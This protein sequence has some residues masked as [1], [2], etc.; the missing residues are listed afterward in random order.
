[1]KSLHLCFFVALAPLAA[2]QTEMLYTIDRP[3]GFGPSWGA[4]LAPLAD[5]DGDGIPDLAVGVDAHGGG[6]AAS[7]HS[8]ADGAHLFDLQ[9]PPQPMFVGRSVASVSR[10]GSKAAP[11]LV[12]IGSRSGAWNSPNGWIGVFSGVD[13]A[14]LRSFTPPAWIAMAQRTPILVLD[15][16]DGDGVED[17]LC[18]VLLDLDGNGGHERAAVMAFSSATGGALYGLPVH[19]ASVVASSTF[20]RVSDH[21]GD[22]LHDFALI[23]RDGQTAFVEIRSSADDTLLARLSP[24]FLAQWTGNAEP[25]ISTADADGDGLRDLALG[26]VFSR[27]TVQFS[28]A[29]GVELVEWTPQTGTDPSF[30][31]RLIEVGDLD[32]DGRADLLALE[33][34][35]FGTDGL[36]LF[37]LDPVRG[38]VVLEAPFPGFTTGYTTT[39]RIAPLAV[40]VL[41]GFPAFVVHE[42]ALGRV[43]AWRHAPRIGERVCI[44]AA[45][46]SGMPASLR[47]FG[48]VERGANRLAFEVLDASAHAFGLFV[49]GNLAPQGPFLGAQRCLTGSVV[50]L[51]SGVA[52]GSGRLGFQVDLTTTRLPA[53]ATTY[54][55][56]LRQPD[57]GRLVATD[58]VMLVLRD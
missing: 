5:L 31:S 33:S 52:D 51:G 28:S 56:F 19:P 12:V 41:S 48:S 23:V 18:A 21:D 24:P 17:F 4:T 40:D 58:A 27:F 44:G 6:R 53:G 20:T 54:Q 45:G 16:L 25:L 34:N 35:A 22:G 50:S 3:A 46:P 7:I 26:G 10:A 42:E 8:G 43:S 29:S 39:T 14:L 36:S 57:N 38:T 37:G 9:V 30:G 1:M 55:A 13:G 32:G 49:H 47:A 2:A 11:E 15:D